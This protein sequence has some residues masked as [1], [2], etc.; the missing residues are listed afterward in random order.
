MFRVL[1]VILQS[2]HDLGRGASMSD[3]IHEAGTLYKTV[4]YAALSAAL[5]FAG[6]FLERLS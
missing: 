1:A 2:A 4:Q 3:G 6:I 5:V